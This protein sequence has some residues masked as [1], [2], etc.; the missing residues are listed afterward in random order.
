[1]HEDTPNADGPPRAAGP[2][3]EVERESRH[4]R[5]GDRT[6]HRHHD[7]TRAEGPAS[8]SARAPLRGQMR[9]HDHLKT[10]TSSDRLTVR[11]GAS[12]GR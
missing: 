1:M 8:A 12:R 9:G 5:R 10:L 11:M 6:P 3:K 2:R 4:V 7:L